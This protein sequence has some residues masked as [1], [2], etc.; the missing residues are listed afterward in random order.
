MGSMVVTERP[1]QYNLVGADAKLVLRSDGSIQGGKIQV[2]WKCNT[3][4][5]STVFN[6]STT[7]KSV[8]NTL[9][10]AEALLTGNFT[11][12]MGRD[13]GCAGRGLFD[14]FVHTIGSHVDDIDA[15]F[16]VWKKCVKCAS[17]NNKSKVLAYSYDVESDTCANGSSR[18]FCECDRKLMKFLN[19]EQLTAVATEYPAGKCQPGNANKLECCQYDTHFWAHYNPERSCCGR[20]G[21]KENGDC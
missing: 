20:D 11:P 10:M 15:A 3:P 4:I 2:D 9:E 14:P 12:E 21:V 13:Y 6:T 7:T 17:G 16:F 19:D 18:S 1:T 8:T 5:T